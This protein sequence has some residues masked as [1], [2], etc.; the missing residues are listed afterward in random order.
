[1]VLKL[2]SHFY[3]SRAVLRPLILTHIQASMAYLNVCPV[4]LS[5]ANL[6]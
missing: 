6:F 4:V 1:M 5:R 2:K 3:L